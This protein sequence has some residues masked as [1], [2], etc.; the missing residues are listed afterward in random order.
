MT[1]HAV[2]L[3]AY[4]QVPEQHNLT[5]QTLET[6]LKQDIGPLDL[7]LID[8][9]S[10]L[11]TTRVHFQMLRDLYIDRMDE[12]HIHTMPLKQNMP[13]VR[14]I[15]RALS[16][17][18]IKGHS[19]VL[20]VPNDV[21]IPPNFYRLLNQWPRGLVTASE[22]RDPHH[23]SLTGAFCEWDVQAISENTPMAVTLVRKWFYDALVA[24]DGM[25]FDEEMENYASDCDLA[26]RMATCGLR[27]VQLNVPY[28]HYGSASWKLLP[29]DDGRKITDQADIDREYFFQKW[30][31]RVFDEQY[32]ASALDIN[33][34][35]ERI[36]T[37]QKA[38]AAS[39]DS[40]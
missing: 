38:A 35:G 25:Y 10:P 27:G 29:Q 17:W 5:V 33:F 23:I 1:R 21:M 34:R 31:F 4:D 16:Y 26:L 28:W 2:I 18:Y 24:R 8:N 6:V 30:G 37:S 20:C 32:V 19:K 14:V 11:E 36:P 22:H 15:N 12:T 7:L 3:L 9:G 13:P 40:K 39:G